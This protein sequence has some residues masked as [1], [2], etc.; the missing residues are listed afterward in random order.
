MSSESPADAPPASASVLVVCTGNVCRSPAAQLL[1]ESR[2][3]AA[4]QTGVHVIS[5]GTRARPGDPVSGPMATLLRADGVDPDAF[6]SRLLADLDIDAADL[7]ITMSRDHRA[8]VVRAVP[9]AVRRTFTLLELALLLSTAPRMD[10]TPDTAASRWRELR[11]VATSQRGRHAGRLD[12]LD[13]P[14]P[15][16]RGA[17]VYGNV[18]GTIARA[19]DAVCRVAIPGTP[20]FERDVLSPA[21][22]VTGSTSSRRPPR[23]SPHP[24]PQRR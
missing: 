19:V 24:G 23:H 21:G 12:D 5:A 15:I 20:G 7:V 11:A 8:A 17:R 6:S 14:D 16:G 3:A 22:P 1:L 10:G 2:L 13:V 9:S 4:G 18:Y